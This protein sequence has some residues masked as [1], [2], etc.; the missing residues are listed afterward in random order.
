M[1]D[2][3]FGFN[4]LRRLLSPVITGSW[5]ILS[6]PGAALADAS[7]PPAAIFRPQLRGSKFARL[8]LAKVRFINLLQNM[9]SR[10][11]NLFANCSNVLA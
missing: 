5:M 2:R 1:G 8:R 9:L 10:T 6:I 3:E 7:L 4:M 11:I